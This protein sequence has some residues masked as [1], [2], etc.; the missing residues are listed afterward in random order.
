M[1]GVGIEAALQEHQRMS[2]LR[3]KDWYYLP[4][5]VQFIGV[6]WGFGIYICICF[7][8]VKL[9]STNKPGSLKY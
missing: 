2:N 8:L 4:I 1:V 3:V 5:K 6:L 7:F 9:T